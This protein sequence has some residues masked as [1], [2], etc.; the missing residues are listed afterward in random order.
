VPEREAVRLTDAGIAV[1]VYGVRW[2]GPHTPMPDHRLLA[3]VAWT[4]FHGHEAEAVVA[5]Q[6]GKV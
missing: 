2:A 5:A 6:I 3:E 4:D 1:S